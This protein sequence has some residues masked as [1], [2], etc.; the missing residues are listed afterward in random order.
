MYSVIFINWMHMDVHNIFKFLFLFTIIFSHSISKIRICLIFH[1]I[2][3]MFIFKANKL[4]HFFPTNLVGKFLLLRR[5]LILFTSL[6]NFFQVSGTAK[7]WCKNFFYSS[8]AIPRLISWF[9]RN[10]SYQPD[11]TSSRTNV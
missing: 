3:Y 11:D 1:F 9:W 4:I 8:G 10:R 2:I 5:D 7:P 6:W